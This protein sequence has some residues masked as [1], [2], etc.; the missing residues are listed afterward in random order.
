M[1]G[2]MSFSIL[3]L[4][5]AISAILGQFWVKKMRPLSR[6]TLALSAAAVIAGFARA[7]TFALV[8]PAII[9]S[10]ASLL[11]QLNAIV[12]NRPYRN[13]LGVSCSLLLCALALN[14]WTIIDPNSLNPNDV[15]AGA[16]LMTCLG[17][18]S[19]GFA[20]TAAGLLRVGEGKLWLAVSAT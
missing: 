14:T 9:L 16:L 20:E 10:G 7:G 1:T 11:P 12:R 17:I 13:V 2:D 3:L 6:A 18:V 19:T 4:L 5:A 8:E 15:V